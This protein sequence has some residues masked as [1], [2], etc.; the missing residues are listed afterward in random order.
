MHEEATAVMRG[1]SQEVM[2]KTCKKQGKSKTKKSLKDKQKMKGNKEEK[3]ERYPENAVIDAR[4]NNSPV[5]RNCNPP[6]LRHVLSL[7]E[8]TEEHL[9]V[10]LARRRAEKYC[11]HGA[12][13]AKQ[14]FA[15]NLSETKALSA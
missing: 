15:S 3:R 13:A 1:L 2:E 9:V 4:K 6:D 11:L 10:E 8:A 5:T 14:G 7:A 12:M